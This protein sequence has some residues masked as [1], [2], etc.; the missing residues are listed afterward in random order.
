VYFVKK[1]TNPDWPGNLIRPGG[2]RKSHAQSKRATR[3]ARCTVL[4]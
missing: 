3:A 4:E 1:F 2:A